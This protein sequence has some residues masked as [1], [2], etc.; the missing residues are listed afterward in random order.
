MREGT[1]TC[2]WQQ[3]REAADILCIH[4]TKSCSWALYQT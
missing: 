1:N 3:C 4:I 2:D